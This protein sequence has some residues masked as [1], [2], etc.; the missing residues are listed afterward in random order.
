[1]A[2]QNIGPQIRI[3]GYK[4]YSDD[5]KNIIAKTKA[6]K[7]EEKLLASQYDVSTTAAD[8]YQDKEN[9]LTKQIELQKEAVAKNEEMLAKVKETYKDGSTE[10]E[11]YKE[12]VAKSR[13]ELN[14]LENELKD[15]RQAMAD[16]EPKVKTGAEKLKEFSEKAESAG[17]KMQDIGDKMTK[18]GKELTTKVTAPLVAIGTAAIKTT[19]DFEQTMAQVQAL[20]GVGADDL[21]K[22]S[23]TAK[24]LGASTSFSAKEVGEGMSYMALAGWDTEQMLDGIAPILDLAAASGTDLATTSDIVTDALTAFGL[25]AKDTSRFVDVLAQT[26]ASSNTT[27][28]GMGEAFKY[29]APLAGALG[30]SIEDISLAL[31]TMANSG[32]KGSAAGTAL[33]STLSRLAK[34]T[35]E[36]QGTLDALGISLTDRRG[37][38]KSLDT[39]LDEMRTAFAGLSEA[40]AAEAAT[41]IAGKNAMSGF[42]A[43]VQTGDDDLKKLKT[44]IKNSNGAAKRMADTMLDTTSGA[45]TIMQS[46]IEGAAISLGEELAPFARKAADKVTELASAFTEMDDATKK[47]V[48]QVGAVAALA[49]PLTVGLGSVVGSVGTITEKTGQLVK[50]LTAHPLGALFAVGAA[51]VGMV[52]LQSYITGVKSRTSELT[53]EI[54]G[55]RT[56]ISDTNSAIEATKT[57]FDKAT[58]GADG[59]AAAANNLIDKLDALTKKESLSNTEKALMAEYVAA[60]NELYPE[61][62]IQIDETGTALNKTTDEMRKYVDMMKESARAEAIKDAYVEAV[63]NQ[64]SAQLNLNRAQEAYEKVAQKS[65]ETEKERKLLQ[66]QV[67]GLTEDRI[68]AEE[69]L[70]ELLHAGTI[71]ADDYNDALA[72][73][74]RGE[75]AVS[76][77]SL[78]LSEAQ[79]RLIKEEGNHIAETNKAKQALD[80]ANASYDTATSEV[81][82]LDAAYEASVTA[83]TAAKEATEA[84]AAAV[85]DSTDEIRENSQ[86]LSDHS[87]Y[88]SQMTDEELDLADAFVTEVDEM[89]AA[90]GKTIDSQMDMFSAFQKGTEISKEEILANMQSQ[91]DGVRNWE[92]NIDT[93]MHRGVDVNILKRLIEMGPQGSNYVEAFVTMS[94]EELA[95][96]SEMWTTSLDIKGMTDEWGTKLQTDAPTAVS[97]GMDGVPE[98]MEGYGTDSA[99]GFI[100]AYNKYNEEHKIE[101]P[102]LGDGTEEDYYTEGQGK[103]SKYAQGL[104]DGYKAPSGIAAIKQTAGLI[105]EATAPVGVFDQNKGYG[106][107]GSLGVLSGL[108]QK[109]QAIKDRAKELREA[110]APTGIYNQNKG[111]GEQGGKGVAVGMVTPAAH[112][113][114]MS[115]ADK[116]K[117][118]SAPKG[119]WGFLKG[120]GEQGGKGVAAGMVTPEANKEILK[121]AGKVKTNTA[122]KGIFNFNKGYGEQG[123]AG[124]AAGMVT[125]AMNKKIVE[126][127][128]KVKKASAPTG[129]WSQNKGYGE[130]GA[131]GVA[132]GLVSDLD[133][134]KT[135]AETLRKAGTPT[136]AKEGGEQAGK[137]L[138]DGFTKGM[139]LKEKIDAA[140][141]KAKAL[142]EAAL[143]ALNEKLDTGSPSK[144]TE[145]IGKMA[146]EGFALGLADEK[147]NIIATASETFDPANFGG[148]PY[149]SGGTAGGNTTYGDTSVTLNVYGAEGQDVRELADIVEQK[150]ALNIRNR[151]AVWA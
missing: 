86:A 27:V 38:M 63:K 28:E 44:A 109:V 95:K 130:Q 89:T 124:V 73:M 41:N 94:D 48:I 49:G 104:D 6:L 132:S 131:S 151:N 135:N 21:G 10:V 81:N 62:N 54:D 137:D 47:V 136:G 102:E 71:T 16:L 45:F 118:D 1:M 15:T 7:A 129:I 82:A 30:Y 46:A 11:K 68:T 120:Y 56:D 76:G 60:L 8:K 4:Q 70:Q 12:I 119:I 121:S 99:K 147:R 122:P 25:S 100:E 72:A 74:G 140:K 64:T 116:V 61:M 143:K 149:G 32:I 58:Q 146:G 125:P 20:S 139:S 50:L 43:L 36:V 90:L 40:E 65:A 35:A 13:A 67:M 133:P 113:E 31:G 144:E 117:K 96:A 3:D 19:A 53:Q 55:L 108:G 69:K 26:S 9:A 17:K 39:L 75:V 93:L 138:A 115:A 107:R 80:E 37:E 112:K 92:Q 84:T 111:Y 59:N 97:T 78:K 88:F 22:L 51:V 14:N 134:V 114:I 127:A 145:Y 24:D 77:S 98:L 66:F 101:A 85:D 23:K 87:D 91:I 52:A 29:V 128:G 150:I 42:L 83:M 5:M 57:A 34:P 106:E 105:K 2:V 18:T 141:E 123:S 33:R 79:S 148:V 103:G 110:S 126:S 142:A